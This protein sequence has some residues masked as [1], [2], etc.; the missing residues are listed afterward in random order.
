MSSSRPTSPYQLRPRA[1]TPYPTRMPPFS[2]PPP[3]ARFNHHPIQQSPDRL[4]L[5]TPPLP[6]SSNSYENTWPEW[7]RSTPTS[8]LAAK[9]T[10]MEPITSMLPSSLLHDGESEIQEVLTWDDSTQTFKEQGISQRG[11]II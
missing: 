5:S 8:P 10:R 11:S 9:S 6:T 7:V 2:L 4:A 1:G 3:L